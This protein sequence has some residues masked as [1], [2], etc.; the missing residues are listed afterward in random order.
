MVFTFEAEGSPRTKSRA[1][2]EGEGEAEGE[3]RQSLASP[4]FVQSFCGFCVGFHLEPLGKRIPS[5]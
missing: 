5:L 1:S 4:S 2:L 3:A